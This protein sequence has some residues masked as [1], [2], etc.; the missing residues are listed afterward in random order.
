MMEP[1]PSEYEGWWRIVETSQWVDDGRDILGP[2]L[3]TLT[4]HGDR[5]R[6]DKRWKYGVLTVGD[7]RFARRHLR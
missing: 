6:D 3:L 4:G 1:I 5:L 7:L 2:A